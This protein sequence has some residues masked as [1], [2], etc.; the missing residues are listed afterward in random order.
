MM[1]ADEEEKAGFVLSDE[2][3]QRRLSLIEFL[4]R[5]Y[6]LTRRQRRKEGGEEGVR[7]G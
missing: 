5:K 1:R 2:V 4:E 7:K 6:E 3:R